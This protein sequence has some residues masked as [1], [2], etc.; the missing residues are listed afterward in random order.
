MLVAHFRISIISF[1]PGS[2]I[3][4]RKVN[5]E[6]DY[7]CQRQF[8]SVRNSFPANYRRREIIQSPQLQPPKVRIAL[9]L[10]FKRRSA[11]FQ[12]IFKWARELS[13]IKTFIRD[14]TM[15][16][17]T[18]CCLY[19]FFCFGLSLSRISSRCFV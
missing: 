5:N 4:E 8:K 1:A 15:S 19:F 11:Q 16:A 9:P 17:T 6:T 2:N 14:T 7:A 10:N 3:V 12:C 13:G 18:V